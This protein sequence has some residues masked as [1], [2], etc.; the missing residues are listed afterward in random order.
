MED[1]DNEVARVLNTKHEKRIESL[2]KSR[3]EWEPFA[4]GTKVWVYKHVRVG[5]WRLQ[6][7]WWGQAVIIRRVGDASYVIQW[8]DNDTQ[9]V[10]IDDLKEY[11]EPIMEREGIE[12]EFRVAGILDGHIP[13]DKKA[14]NFL[15]T[16]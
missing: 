11:Q 5:G 8:G 3:K 6:A 1:I 2:N 10:H 4:L 9:L 15:C 16:E 7:R 13:E 12:L 14:E